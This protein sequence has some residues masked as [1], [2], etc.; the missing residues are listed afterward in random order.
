MVFY[1]VWVDFVCFHDW[2]SLFYK[3]ARTILVI[4]I[5]LRELE[6]GICRSENGLSGKE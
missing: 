6:G 1:H 5:F 4:V 3:N 2:L